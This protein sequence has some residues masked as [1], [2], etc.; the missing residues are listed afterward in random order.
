[1]E[2]ELYEEAEAG[3]KKLS[4]YEGVEVEVRL[5][6][7]NRYV[8]YSKRLDSSYI[9]TSFEEAINNILIKIYNN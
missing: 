8:V 9:I 1:M 4:T 5:T 7:G 6:L 3:L 2:V